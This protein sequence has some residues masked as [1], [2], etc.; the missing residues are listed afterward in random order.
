MTQTNI[1]PT[2]LTLDESG[3]LVSLDITQHEITQSEFE[4]LSLKEIGLNPSDYA[5]VVASARTIDINNPQSINKF[6]SSLG[7]KSKQSTNDLLQM[8]KAKDLD[9]I[10]GQLNQILVL[11]QNNNSDNLFNKKGLSKLPIVGGIIDRITKTSR[12]IANGMQNTEQML[13]S[14]VTEI[15]TNKDGLE[16]RIN[17]L[18]LMH[19]HV[20]SEYHELGIHIAS[21]RLTVKMIDDSIDSIPESEKDDQI[22]VQKINDMI[23]TRNRLEK[24]VSDLYL[25]QQSCLQTLPQIRII[26]HNSA[27]LIDKF[28]AIQAVTLPAWKNQIS[29]TLTLEDQQRSVKLTEAIDDTTNDL[30]KRNAQLLRQNSVATAKS[31]QRS[32][33]DVD[34]LKKVQQEL[35]LT[36]Q[37]TAKITE[38][39]KVARIQQQKELAKLQTDLNKQVLLQSEN[40]DAISLK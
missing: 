10:G 24:R 38:D 27:A 34:T 40:K 5:E 17:H 23:N 12:G 37:E 39:G 8:V 29:L 11:A 21:G 36:V 4:S 33:I 9:E 28:H 31:N 13:D 18:E 2:T 14:I 7:E 35:V 20:I 3:S 16:S 19:S 22:I 32:V 15:E 6:G 1:K 25:L 26:Q 30:L